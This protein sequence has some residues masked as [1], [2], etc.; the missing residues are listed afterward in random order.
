MV[1]T[2]APDRQL[3]P[4]ERPEWTVEEEMAER[5]RLR[6]A[7]S[8]DAIREMIADSLSAE[9]V[10]DWRRNI[11][12]RVPRVPEY[13]DAIRTH[14]DYVRQMVEQYIEHELQSQ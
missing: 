4:P 1:M 8:D 10:A 6:E 9:V 2:Q 12:D 3:D 5:Q 14:A 11:I 13:V 7:L